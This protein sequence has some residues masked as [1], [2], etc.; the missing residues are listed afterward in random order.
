[1]FSKFLTLT[2]LIFSAYEMASAFIFHEWFNIII[3][4]FSFNLYILSEALDRFEEKCE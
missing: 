2:I 4:I 1:M 3:S